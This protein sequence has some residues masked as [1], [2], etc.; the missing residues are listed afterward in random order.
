MFNEIVANRGMIYASLKQ[1][2]KK[3][4][5]VDGTSEIVFKE[6]PKQLFVGTVDV[7]YCN[8]S[9]SSPVSLTFLL[10]HGS[11]RHCLLRLCFFQNLI[12]QSWHDLCKFEAGAQEIAAG[13]R[14]VGD[15]FQGGA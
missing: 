7:V 10:K 4:Q 13:G 15:R 12:C 2:L 1:E 9:M 5:L 14:Y 11:R 3:L 6:E 8:T